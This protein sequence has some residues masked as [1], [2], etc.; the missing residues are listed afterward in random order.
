METAPKKIKIPKQNKITSTN[1]TQVFIERNPDLNQFNRYNWNVKAADIG[2]YIQRGS[3]QPETGGIKP[4]LLSVCLPP[5]SPS[6]QLN[7][8]KAC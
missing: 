8:C 4:S 3:Q 5:L 7:L 6:A 2:V 1:L